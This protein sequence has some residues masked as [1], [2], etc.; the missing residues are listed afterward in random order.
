MITAWHRSDEVSKRLDE[1]A[2]VG[3]TLATA[4]SPALLI[5]RRFDQDETYLGANATKNPSHLQRER[6]PAGH[7]A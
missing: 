7:P 2:G 4:L 3:P 6:D 1:L 5:R